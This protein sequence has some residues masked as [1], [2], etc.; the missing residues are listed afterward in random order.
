MPV[1]SRGEK[2]IVRMSKRFETCVRAMKKFSAVG[3]SGLWTPD[4]D[5][6]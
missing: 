4:R 1:Y 2:K 6:L 3:F 5:S